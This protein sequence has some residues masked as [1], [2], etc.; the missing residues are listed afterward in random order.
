[1]GN[2]QYKLKEKSDAELHGWLA[3]HESDTPEYLAGIRELMERNDA[4]VNRREWIAMGAAIISIIVAIIA[5]VL[6]SE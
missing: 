2:D 1:M 3:G 6:M 5:V 4:P